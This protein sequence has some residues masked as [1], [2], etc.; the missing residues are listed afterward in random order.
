MKVGIAVATAHPAAKIRPILD[1]TFR[2]NPGY[3]LVAFNRLSAEQQDLF[4]NLR[5]DPDFFGILRPKAGQQLAVK[6]ACRDTALLF[7]ALQEQGA[8][9]PFVLS[10][11]PE[12][13]NRAMAKLV[14]DAVFE[15]ETGGRMV[16]GAEALDDIVAENDEPLALETQ[17]SEIARLSRQALQYGQSLPFN[18]SGALSGRLYSYGRVPMSPAWKRKFPGEGA[19]RQCLGLDQGGENMR[20]L[21]ACWQALPPDPDNDGWIAFQSRQA[22]LPAT[23]A[24]KLYVSPHPDSL[25]PAFDAMVPVLAAARANAF[26]VGKDLAGMLRPDKFVAYF[27]SFEQVE[28]AAHEILAKLSGCPSQ[29]VPFTAELGSPLVSWGI[30]PPSD[31]D[32]PVWLSRQSW[33]LWVTNRLA[34]ALLAGKQNEASGLEPWKFAVERLRL[35]GVDTDTWTPVGKE[36]N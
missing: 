17:L 5:R 22:P 33:R 13:A 28:Q 1:R 20:R 24:Y 11:E 21:D 18:D 14:L 29:G 16:H 36:H 7:F 12:E 27:S 30:D 8:L 32:A 26:K 31:K 9:P 3:E 35:E 19:V 6:S 25:R 34:V 15:I 2:A 23:T 4:A 10:G